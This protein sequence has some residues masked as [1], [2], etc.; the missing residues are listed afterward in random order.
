MTGWMN[1]SQQWDR[2]VRVCALIVASLLVSAVAADRPAWAANPGM[3]H[4]VETDP[5]E[6]RPAEAG[7]SVRGNPKPEAADAR[8]AVMPLVYVPPARG[9]ARRTTGGAT[10]SSTIEGPRVA[11]L[12]PRDHVGLTSIA[13]PR[14]YWHLSES[15][16]RQ[17]VLTVVDDEAIEPLVAL[18]LPGPVSAGV[19]ALDLAALGVEL[20]T[21]RAYR[22]F[23]AVVHDADHRSRDAIAEGA[24]ERIGMAGHAVGADARDRARAGL[25]YDAL[26]EIQTAIEARPAEQSLRADLRALLDQG[27]VEIELP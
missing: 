9:R 12:T 23:V 14:L 15:T 21:G 22:W 16:Q 17:V 1:R 11:V 18:R 6:K 8:S 7:T 5:L 26:D 10:R 3:R 19:H 24:V 25:W 27:H 4:E 13:S 2:V 20:E